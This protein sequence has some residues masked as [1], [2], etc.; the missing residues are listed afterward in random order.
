MSRFGRVAAPSR[1]VV[2][3]PR[4]RSHACGRTPRLAPRSGRGRLARR[5]PR[6]VRATAA[7]SPLRTTPIA[8]TCATLRDIPIAAA[9]RPLGA[10]GGRHRARGG[11]SRPRT[12]S[13]RTAGDDRSLAVPDR[14]AVRHRR[15]G[16]RR[17]RDGA[18]RRLAR[19][20]DRRSR[21]ARRRSPARRQGVAIVTVP[22]AATPMVVAAGNVGWVHS[23][24]DGAFAYITSPVDQVCPVDDQ[25]GCAAARR[26]A[27]ERITLDS[28]PRTII[29][30]P[31]DDQA[32]V[33]G[34]DGSGS[35]QV[36]VMSLPERKRTAGRPKPCATPRR[37]ADTDRHPRPP[38]RR[39]PRPPPSEPSATPRGV[40]RSRR[41][42]N[43]R[44][45]P[46]TATPDPTPTAT[47]E[48]TPARPP[49]RRRS[50]RPARR[51]PRAAIAIASGV[52]VVG[53][54][55]AFSADGTLVRVHG[56]TVGRVG[57]AGHLRVAHGRRARR[58]A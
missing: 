16:H 45:S 10:D 36:F 55:A 3:G 5:A 32:V 12:A 26:S 4:T 33:V 35:D 54:S 15:G 48:P 17:R 9:A 52:T 2:L 53:Q 27:A 42:T 24:D 18:I 40:R 23:T 20:A 44:P 34:S 49:S 57:R 39:R 31:T 43:R 47:P 13:R 19:P 30:S 25:P 37:D 41:A 56:A 21:P 51:R 7:R 58:S 1:P 14:R 28:T 11:A 22:P 8:S 50:R 46:G 29:G 38:R 6:R